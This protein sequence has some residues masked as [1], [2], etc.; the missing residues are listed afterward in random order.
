MGFHQPAGAQ[1]PSAVRGAAGAL[2]D[3]L[4]SNLVCAPACCGCH[5]DG[6][7]IDEHGGP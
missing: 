7:A 4:G 5:L 1:S 2:N 6:D 3:M